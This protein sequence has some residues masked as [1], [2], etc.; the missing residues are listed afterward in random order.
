MNELI[1][2]RIKK[3][4]KPE[5]VRLFFKLLKILIDELRFTPDNARLSLTIPKQETRIVVN[6]NSR[7][8]LVLKANASFLFMVDNADYK[9]LQKIIKSSY[10]EDFRNQALVDAHLVEYPLEKLRSEE[11]LSAIVKA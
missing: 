4:N 6:I 10:H 1:H 8:A 9:K 3:I 11:V 7:Y 2:E 5:A